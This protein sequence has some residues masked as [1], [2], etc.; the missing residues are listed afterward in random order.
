[1]YTYICTHTHT[2]I[3]IYIYSIW[4]FLH[5]HSCITGWQGKGEDISLAPHYHFH[6]LHRHLDISWA[7]TTESSPLYIESSQTQTGNLW[8]PTASRQ[9]LSYAPLSEQCMEIQNLSEP[10]FFMIS[11]ST[12]FKLLH[13]R[14]IW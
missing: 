6:L 9:P 13:F 2:H 7:I 10:E 11:L 1:M 3:Y 4:V 12:L 5:D 8:F 14:C